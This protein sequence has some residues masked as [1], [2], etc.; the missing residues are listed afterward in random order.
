L[1]ASARLFT[2]I[3]Y[4]TSTGFEEPVNLC[5][6]DKMSKRKILLG[7]PVVLSLLLSAC[8]ASQGGLQTPMVTQPGLG[9]TQSIG[10]AQTEQPVTLPTTTQPPAATQSPQPSEG[11]ASTQ[12]LPNTGAVDPGLVS[13]LLEFGV[14][15]QDNQIIGDVKDMIFNL[16]T[17]NAEYLVVD[18]VGFLGIGG[19]LVAIP[20]DRFELVTAQEGGSAAQAPQNAFILDASVDALKDAP[21]FDPQSLPELGAPAGKWDQELK[22]YWGSSALSGS[23]ATTAGPQGTQPPENA[24]LSQLQGVVLASDVLGFAVQGSQGE[25]L[26]EVKDVIIDAQSGD[27]QYALIQATGIEALQNQLIPIP[28]DALKIDMENGVFVIPAGPQVLLGAPAFQSQSLPDTAQ[29]NW[30]A[31]IRSY[32]RN[33]Q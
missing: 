33:N 5:K 7:V 25:T 19:K 29:P 28:M 6:E 13:N 31:Q 21:E 10:E 1:K 15:R 2:L 9:T 30:D 24:A 4:A 8:G 14:W 32:W 17:R 22:S 20:Y 27:I 23:Q 18:V 26:V 12:A 3:K 16:R 11:A